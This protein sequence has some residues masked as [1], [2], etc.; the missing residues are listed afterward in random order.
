MKE[1]KFYFRDEYNPRELQDT[2][3]VPH[4][5]VSCNV[6]GCCVCNE[7][8]PFLVRNNPINL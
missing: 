4:D 8:V 7:L 6:K 2:L 3:G 5:T 1:E